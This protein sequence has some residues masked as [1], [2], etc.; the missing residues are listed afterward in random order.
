MLVTH[1]DIRTRWR[2]TACLRSCFD[3]PST[4]PY[5]SCPKAEIQRIG[6]MLKSRYIVG[7]GALDQ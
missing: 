3:A 5:H 1:P 4:L 6:A 2:S 7:A